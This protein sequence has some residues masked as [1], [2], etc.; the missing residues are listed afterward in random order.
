MIRKPCFPQRVRNYFVD[1][2]PLTFWEED[3]VRIAPD[4]RVVMEEERKLKSTA[5]KSTK[6]YQSRP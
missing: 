3:E 1:K 2:T 6:N 5:N 4:L